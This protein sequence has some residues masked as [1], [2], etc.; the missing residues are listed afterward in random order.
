MNGTP[1]T[2]NFEA[3]RAE[4]EAICDES[5]QGSSLYDFMSAGYRESSR[6]YLTSSSDLAAAA[7]Q[8]GGEADL[9]KI[10]QVIGKYKYPFAVKSGGHSMAPSFSS[11]SG[12]IQISMT[13][14][15]KIKYDESK[16]LLHVGAG[17]L[18]GAVYRKASKLG[19]GVVGGVNPAVG[20]GGLLLGG[21]YSLKS[22]RL[23]LAI[24]N[25]KAF[26]I[27]TPKG[28]ILDVSDDS[29]GE[30]KELYN[31]L[32][33]GANNFGIV[34]RFTLYTHDQ[35]STYGA[36]LVIPKGRI[37]ERAVK[38]A[39]MD[40]ILHEKRKTAAIEVAFRHNLLAGHAKPE[41]TISANCVFDEPRPID[42]SE[43]P[44][45]AFRKIVKES[46]GENP[47]GWDPVLAAVD[48]QLFAAPRAPVSGEGASADNQSDEQFSDFGFREMSLEKMH[49]LSEHT[50]NI[51]SFRPEDL[52]PIE[53]KRKAASDD[54]SDDVD[55]F[56]L[57]GEGIE[58]I[59][60][61]LNDLGSPGSDVDLGVFAPDV[62]SLQPQNTIATVSRAPQV[63]KGGSKAQPPLK[64]LA[65]LGETN[66][67]RVYIHF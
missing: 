30:D 27:V 53:V 2:D 43:V 9:A 56:T 14:F 12:G 51:A 5:T 20:V 28:L 66:L 8:P 63:A 21:G 16:Q 29:T 50:Y 32:R 40:H 34:T 35:T 18:W 19:R 48:A 22:S 7:V 45:A 24:D 23:G 38:E 39:I 59:L 60:D 65:N 67:R 17:S 25:V 55:I 49:L 41:Y 37:H 54:K 58:F 52:S 57:I 42:P 62:P 10:I 26:R 36:M 31:A 6:H 44:F 61:V 13:R 64:P 15:D 11:T 1:Q 33:G 3:L 47:A 46:W 4:L